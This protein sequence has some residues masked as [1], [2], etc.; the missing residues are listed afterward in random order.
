[1][2]PKDARIAVPCRSSAVAP[3]SLLQMRFRSRSGI[4]GPI[5]SVPSNPRIQNIRAATSVFYIQNGT[6]GSEV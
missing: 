1:M 6:C 5:T 4:P 3:F 2:T